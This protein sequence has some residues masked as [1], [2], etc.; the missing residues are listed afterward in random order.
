MRRSR[1][2]DRKTDGHDSGG[3]QCVL[4]AT[5]SWAVVAIVCVLL[6]LYLMAHGDLFN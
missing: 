1:L 6:A 4:G 3:V 2:D 5:F